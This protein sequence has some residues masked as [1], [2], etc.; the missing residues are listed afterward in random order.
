VGWALPAHSQGPLPPNNK[1]A[2]H[3]AWFE[4]IYKDF[5]CK[6][7]IIIPTKKLSYHG[8]FTHHVEIMRKGS[9]R[10]LKDS[11]RSFFKEFSKYSIHEVS[12]E[13]VQQLIDTHNLDL[14]SL[15]SD[16]SENYTKA[17]K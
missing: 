10:K 14:E 13:K 12:D 5:E 1:A 2:S 8:D 4:S 3:S 17:V 16:Y 9:L 6:R 7:I 11:V 15:K